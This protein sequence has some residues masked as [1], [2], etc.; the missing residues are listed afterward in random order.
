MPKSDTDIEDLVDRA[1]REIREE[2]EDGDRP[3]VA[4]KARELRV[5][6]DRLYRR[7]KGVGPRIARKPVNHRLSA[8]QEGSLLRY[9][10]T[11]DEIRVAIWYDR[12]SLVANAILAEDYTNNDRTLSV[13]KH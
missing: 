6:K 8:V 11:L 2:E 12:I 1:V 3:N 13:G 4:A 9:I 7:L 5:P 10:H